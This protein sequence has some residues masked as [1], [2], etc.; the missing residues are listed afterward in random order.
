MEQRN[1]RK[2]I[3]VALLLVGLLAAWAVWPS[4]P[5]PILAKT[6]QKKPAHKR[7]KHTFRAAPE[8][9]P[10]ET[11]PAMAVPVT[12]EGEVVALGD[13]DDPDTG[14]TPAEVTIHVLYSD[15]SPAEDRLLLE[16]S[17]CHLWSGGWGPDVT[18]STTAQA[19]T[20]RVGRPDG[21]L[22][23]WS[24]P[25]YVELYNGG[26]A[27]LSAVIPK[28]ETGGLGVSF[29]RDVDGMVVEHVMPGSPADEMGLLEGE[30]ITEVNGLP[31][32]A[33]TEDEFVSVMTGPVGTSVDF[34]VGED[35][36]TGFEEHSLELVRSRID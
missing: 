10:E 5:P 18:F 34:V 33:L 27:E 1:R 4:P 14:P 6:A 7:T 15:G 36:D 26:D 22:V 23:A 11:E 2:T 20:V 13:V 21:R 8:Q 32:A 29:S 25:L 35:V 28:E 3:G 9:D 19:C 17:D 16:S 12:P 31:T 30:V 24:D